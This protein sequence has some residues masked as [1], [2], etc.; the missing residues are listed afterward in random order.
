MGSAAKSRGSLGDG[1]GLARPCSQSLILRTALDSS[2]LAA[3]LRLGCSKASDVMIEEL[4]APLPRR[5]LAHAVLVG[6]D[7]E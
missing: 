3:L 2:Q 1:L 6:L 4:D 5:L 7:K